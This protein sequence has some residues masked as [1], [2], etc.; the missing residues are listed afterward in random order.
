MWGD[1]TGKVTCTLA[2]LVNDYTSIALDK[3]T[4]LVL[5]NLLINSI[6]TKTSPHEKVVQ[7][8]RSCLFVLQDA[9]SSLLESSQ[10]D[11]TFVSSFDLIVVHDIGKTSTSIQFHT[12]F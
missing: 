8:S 3:A 6:K 4:P 10:H 12:F 5:Q 7:G 9:S 2:R 11:P 1:T